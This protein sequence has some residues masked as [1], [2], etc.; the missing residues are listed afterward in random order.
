VIPHP[1]LANRRFVLAP[2]DE[3]A[4]EVTLADGRTP[5]PGPGRPGRRPAGHRVSHHSPR[6]GLDPNIS[7]G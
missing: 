4:P 1:E 6:R 7:L 2:L 5:R 3:L